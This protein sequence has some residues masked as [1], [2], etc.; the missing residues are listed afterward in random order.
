MHEAATILMRS[1]PGWVEHQASDANFLFQYKDAVM[2][3]FPDGSWRCVIP[4]GYT[5]A[6]RSGNLNNL[7]RFLQDFAAANP[8]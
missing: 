7:E 8:L 3:V 1:A 4:Q 5:Q 2:T 6:I